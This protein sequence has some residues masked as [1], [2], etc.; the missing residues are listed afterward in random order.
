[1]T[2]PA[3]RAIHASAM[4]VLHAIALGDDD[5]GS[6]RME[7]LERLYGPGAVPGVWMHWG[8]VIAKDH[9]CKRIPPGSP[10]IPGVE[11]VR[12][13]E[14][15]AQVVDACRGERP[16]AAAIGDVFDLACQEELIGDVS[17]SL[18]LVAC[19]ILYRK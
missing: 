6:S 17:G 15:A 10:I 12:C 3:A 16:D 1:M 4:E 11:P 5:C 9:L 18:A 14:L 2:E 19:L 8:C 7:L 13:Y